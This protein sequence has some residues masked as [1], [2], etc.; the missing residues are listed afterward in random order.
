[1]KASWRP[2]W[3]WA[4][5]HHPFAFAAI[6]EVIAL[7]GATL[8]FVDV[9]ADTCSIDT[10]LIEAA[11]TKH[12][13]AILPVSLWQPPD[14]D[15]INAIAVRHGLVVIVDAAQSFGATYRGK[16]TGALSTISCTSFFPSRPLGRYVRQD[17]LVQRQIRHRSPEPGVLGLQFF[18]PLHLV[19]LQAASFRH[20]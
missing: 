20:R 19:A 16:R 3:G 1:M 14:M 11:I 10:R 2:M 12:T 6:S 17:Q 4:L 5:Y 15:E 7:V 9:E 8:V 18:Q 13:R